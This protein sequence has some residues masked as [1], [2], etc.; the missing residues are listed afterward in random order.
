MAEAPWAGSEIEV[1]SGMH[2]CSGRRHVRER[3]AS[4]QGQSP[5][6]AGERRRN[7]R[8]LVVD[9]M[10][11]SQCGTSHASRLSS[12]WSDRSCP[13]PT[14]RSA[15]IRPYLTDL[16]KGIGS[17]TTARSSSSAR[18]RDYRLRQEFMAPSFITQE[19]LSIP[20]MVATGAADPQ[21]QDL[22]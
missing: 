3:R 8:W 21:R 13:S 2:T 11:E 17:N 10:D 22:S 4:V 7:R 15:T 9:G 5:R 18:R 1:W 20:A 16:A 12:A 14:H 6:A 19:T